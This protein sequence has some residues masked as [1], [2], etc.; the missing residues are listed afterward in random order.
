MGFSDEQA[1]ECTIIAKVEVMEYFDRYLNEVFPRQMKEAR[2]DM[3]LM[4][5]G[6]NTSA[7]AHGGA[8]AKVNRVLWGFAGI[9]AVA[10]LAATLKEVFF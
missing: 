1:R 5:A 9:V 2:Q 7:K 6:H 4:I 3:H 8:E 10:G